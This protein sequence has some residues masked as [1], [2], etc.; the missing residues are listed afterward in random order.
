MVEC[1]ILKYLKSIKNSKYCK[2]N[3]FINNNEN[4]NFKNTFTRHYYFLC[5]FTSNTVTILFKSAKLTLE[6]LISHKSPVS[7]ATGVTILVYQLFLYQNLYILCL[8]TTMKIIICKIVSQHR[9]VVSLVSLW[10]QCFVKL[11]PK[12]CVYS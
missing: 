8:N 3:I 5:Q 4:V 9:T 7:S 2:K 10:S 11:Y 6:A 12:H 1:S